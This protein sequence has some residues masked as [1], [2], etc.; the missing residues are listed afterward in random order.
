LR[1]RTVL[2]ALAG[3]CLLAA[4][5]GGDDAGSAGART[6]APRPGQLAGLRVVLPGGYSQAPL[7][8][9]VADQLEARKAKGAGGPRPITEMAYTAV[10]RDGTEK[11]AVLVVS[12]YANVDVTSAEFASQQRAQAVASGLEAEQ[13]TL[14]GKQVLVATGGTDSI[15]WALGRDLLVLLGDISLHD[16]AAL[17]QIATSLIA[18]NT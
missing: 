17:R 6:A 1:A 4:G 5:C 8:Q 10:R 16:Q 15:S 2:I 14:A 9:A 13:G 7:P 11:S 12:R 3:A 18:A